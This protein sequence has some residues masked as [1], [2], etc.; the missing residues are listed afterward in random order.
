MDTLTATTS[1][2]KLLNRKVINGENNV[3]VVIV[4]E[5]LQGTMDIRIT[6]GDKEIEI[7]V[8]NEGDFSS[9]LVNPR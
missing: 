6:L 9:L 8:N 3:E 5:L 1:N 2:S 7:G 4:H